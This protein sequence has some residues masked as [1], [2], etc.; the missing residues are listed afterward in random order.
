VPKGPRL[1]LGQHDDLASA[2]GESLEH[3]LE[4][5]RLRGTGF[6]R[7]AAYVA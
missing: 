3:A 5:T 6:A 1:V 2:L 7:S 4:A